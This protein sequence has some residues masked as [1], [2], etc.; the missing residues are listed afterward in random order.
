MSMTMD[1]YPPASD[2]NE[3]LLDNA[4][5]L[6]VLNYGDGS[7]TRVRPVRLFPLSEPERWISLVDEGGREVQFIADADELLPSS[8]DALVRSL[9]ETEFNP[10]ILRILK[11]TGY[12][13]PC[14]WTVETDRGRTTIIINDD[15]D[16]RYVGKHR[17]QIIDAHGIRYLIMDVSRLD[18]YSRRVIDWY[19]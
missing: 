14:E 7:R 15:R 8:R 11:I 1:A 16:L 2:G 18:P 4:G 12:D 19:I 3:L 10:N 13:V 5:F 6:V 9:R 17:V